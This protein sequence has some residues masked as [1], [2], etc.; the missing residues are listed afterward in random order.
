MASVKIL[1]LAI[2]TIAKPISNSLKSQAKQHPR[3]RKFCIGLA[4]NIHRTEMRARLHLLGQDIQAVRPLNE[5]TAV[6]N[7]ANFIAEGFLFGVATSLIVAEQWRSSRKETRRREGVEDRIDDLVNGVSELTGTVDA[8][9]AQLV[10]ERERSDQMA[11]V[12]NT[13]IQVGLHQALGDFADTPLR[14]PTLPA[15]SDAH[16]PAPPRDTSPPD[17]E[18]DS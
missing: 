12:L 8:L 11:R 1:T 4:Q 16:P 7:G 9:R 13:V 2:R 10:E 14:V 18:S 15:P 5:K 3:F 17:P 6:E